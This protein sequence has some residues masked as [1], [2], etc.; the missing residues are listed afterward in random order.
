LTTKTIAMTSKKVDFSRRSIMLNVAAE[1]S[2]VRASQTD[3]L[4][5]S[6]WPSKTAFFGNFPAFSDDGRPWKDDDQNKDLMALVVLD[7]FPAEV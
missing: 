3:D 6:S 1:A 4:E 7:D 2:N 5:N